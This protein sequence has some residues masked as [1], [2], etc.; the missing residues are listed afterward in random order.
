MWLPLLLN[1]E[2][3]H[4]LKNNFPPAVISQD[5][6]IRSEPYLK[7]NNFI[8]SFFMPEDNKCKIYALR[9]FE[10][11]LYPFLINRK[12]DKIFLALD[13]KCPF[14]KENSGNQK[15][16]EYIQYL[17]DLFH[18]PSTIK[19]IRQNPQVMQIYGDTLNLAELKL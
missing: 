18:A 13:L 12:D 2:I 16:K 1:E 15:F 3:A 11:Q 19:I 14:V 9:P 7:E 17:T 5:K 6:R 8:C 4:L 10:C